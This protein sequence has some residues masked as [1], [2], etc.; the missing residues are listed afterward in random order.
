MSIN[1]S[2]AFFNKSHSAIT[3]RCL[4]TCFVYGDGEG[5]LRHFI[6]IA[7]SQA[8]EKILHPSEEKQDS[9]TEIIGMVAFREISMDYIVQQIESHKIPFDVFFLPIPD[10]L[11]P[12][13]L[14]S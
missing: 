7:K 8:I 10:K 14:D 5:D 9:N 4:L 2:T 13:T 3:N 1:S 6:E 11:F 12:E